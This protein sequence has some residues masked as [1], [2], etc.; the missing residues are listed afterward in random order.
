M[1]KKLAALL[2]VATV[3]SVLT[4]GCSRTTTKAVETPGAATGKEAAGEAK[5]GE[6][7]AAGA[8]TAAGVEQSSVAAPATPAAPG[9][10]PSTPAAATP[11]VAAT[12]EGAAP[13][14]PGQTPVGGEATGS[15][16]EALVTPPGKTGSAGSVPVAPPGTPTAGNSYNL[17]TIY[18]D[19]DKSNIRSDAQSVLDTNFEVLSK[20]PSTKVQ[21]VG[22]CDERGSNEYNMALGD[23]RATSTRAYLINRGIQ[24]DRLTTLSKGEEEP[25][26][27]GHNE[28]AWQK[29]RRAQFLGQ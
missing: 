23:R 29:N 4:A 24:A 20:N 7:G 17:Y 3:L 16:T 26:D 15:R 2:A 27:A 19:F 12:P 25:V 22:H 18:F 28:A 21:I 13:A 11:G 9:E 8:P 5:P 6:P 1:N 10:A 14:T